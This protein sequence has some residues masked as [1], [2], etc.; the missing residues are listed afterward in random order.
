VP[1]STGIVHQVNIE[2]LASVVQLRTLNG[3]KVAFPDSLVGT[4]SH[5]TMVNGMGVLGWGVGGIEAEAV[6]LGQPISL[7]SP[8]VVGF[9]M[10]GELPE[11]TTATDLVLT[12]TQMLRKHG[13][14]GKFVEFYGHGLSQLSVA[15]RATLSNMAPEY[16]ATSSIFP[17]DDQTL[18]YL[19]AT[20]REASQVDLVERYAKDQAMFRADEIP[21]PEFS[22]RLELDLSTV[23]PSLSGPLLPQERVSLSRVKRSF[24]LAFPKQFKAPERE[25]A[26]VATRRFDW[27]GGAANMQQEQEAKTLGSRET[28]ELEPEQLVPAGKAVEVNFDG[29]QAQVGDGSVV[30]AAITSCTNTS[31]P[32]V[33]IGAGL[34]AKKAVE[35]GLSVRPSSR[36]AWRQAPAW[37]QT[38]WKRPD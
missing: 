5:T 7:L 30:I 28:K 22:E 1:P 29:M 14:V 16:G 35:R 33:M 32:S 9:H 38:T 19:R 24:R 2:Y 37:S 17:V 15:D 8:V 18:A 25:A 36:P 6:L 23:E 20:G 34:L 10:H 31:N 4:D 3:M 11:G 13:V 21:D 27:E 12:V 26:N